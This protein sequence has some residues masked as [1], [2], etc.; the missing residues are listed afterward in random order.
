MS[1]SI[2]ISFKKKY[3][4]FMAS[5]ALAAFVS[6][7]GDLSMCAGYETVTDRQES[8]ALGVRS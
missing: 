3:G 6:S 5:L 1:T 8:V 4:S 7:V 2:S